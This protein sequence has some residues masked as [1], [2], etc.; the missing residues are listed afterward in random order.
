M[1]L[2]LFGSDAGALATFL[3]QHAALQA[4]VKSWDL[5]LSMARIHVRR[6]LVAPGLAAS[7]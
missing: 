2:V 3:E 5:L 1:F 7:K 4:H 6:A